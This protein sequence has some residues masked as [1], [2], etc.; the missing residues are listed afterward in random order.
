VPFC[1]SSRPA[2][3]PRAANPRRAKKF[4]SLEVRKGPISNRWNFFGPGPRGPVYRR[5]KAQNE[6]EIL[7]LRHADGRISDA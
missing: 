1:L 3:P 2:S 5:K 4:Q 7:I 6:K